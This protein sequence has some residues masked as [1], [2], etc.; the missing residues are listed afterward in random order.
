MMVAAAQQY[1]GILLFYFFEGILMPVNLYTW[2]SLVA[3][4]VKPPAMEETWFNPW[5]GKIL[6]RRERLP[7]PY[8]GL[9]NAMGCIVHAASLGS[10]PGSGRSSGEGNGNP[11]QYFCLENSMDGG[12]W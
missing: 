5:V 11:L 9:E 4:L 3:Q 10:V 6:W 12:D 1:E 7:T 8:S 2:A